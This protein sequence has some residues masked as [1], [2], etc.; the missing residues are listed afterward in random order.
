ML[1]Q[2]AHLKTLALG[3]ERSDHSK[4]IRSACAPLQRPDLRLLAAPSLSQPCR[5]ALAPSTLPLPPIRARCALRDAPCVTACT[6]RN[7]TRRCA[8]RRETRE[9][10][11]RRRA[12]RHVARPRLASK[13]SLHRARPLPRQSRPRARP[14][15]GHPPGQGRGTLAAPTPL[16]CSP[17]PCFARVHHHTY[18]CVCY[19]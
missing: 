11:P 4:K 1:S 8:L 7:A 17:C 2:R 16:A 3:T 9:A 12:A 15:S 13:S 6:A 19:V 18:L 5:C 14:A 10:A